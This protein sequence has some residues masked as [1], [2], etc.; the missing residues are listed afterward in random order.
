MRE[1]GLHGTP[2]QADACA[3]AQMA[4]L[5]EVVL[6]ARL[7]VRT[8]RFSTMAHVAQAVAAA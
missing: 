1:S 8:T 2:E 3:V 5:R 7:G 4:V 6:E